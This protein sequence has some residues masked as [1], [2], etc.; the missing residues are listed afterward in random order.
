MAANC[1]NEVSKMKSMKQHI[2]LDE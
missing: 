1:V 2:F